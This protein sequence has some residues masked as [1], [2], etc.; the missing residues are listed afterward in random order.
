MALLGFLTYAILDRRILNTKL[1]NAISLLW[2]EKTFS[3]ITF[4]N[5]AEWNYA[6]PAKPGYTRVAVLIQKVAGS[7]SNSA[8]VNIHG[9]M[10]NKMI[11]VHAAY[12][13]ITNLTIHVVAVYIK[14][15]FVENI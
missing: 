6:V 5:S 9:D 2:T 8:I 14:D 15:E 10:P 4:R 13:N 11:S 3:S 1:S 7:G 12:N